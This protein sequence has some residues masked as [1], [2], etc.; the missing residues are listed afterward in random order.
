MDRAECALHEHMNSIPI[1][2]GLN[3]LH[4]SLSS[5]L[6][7]S[8]V[9]NP[10]LKLSPNTHHTP[11]TNLVDSTPICNSDN[12]K[13]IGKGENTIQ[14]MEPLEFDAAV[15]SPPFTTVH[16]LPWTLLGFQA[17]SLTPKHCELRLQQTAAM[18]QNLTQG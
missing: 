6:E 5:A 7:Q 11:Q 15:H 2:C 17:F 3:G 14:L 9:Y 12:M 8:I 18:N 1:G 13:T 16:S 4:V 10:K